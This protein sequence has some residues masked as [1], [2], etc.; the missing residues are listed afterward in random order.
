[1]M[2]SSSGFSDWYREALR[3]S[4]SLGNP[5][6]LFGAFCKRPSQ[7][8]VRLLRRRQQRHPARR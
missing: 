4:A 3:C 1:M 6:D 2:F 5:P 7:R 8:Q